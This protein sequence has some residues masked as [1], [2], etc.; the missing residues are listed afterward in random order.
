MFY[1]W[2]F[3][4]RIMNVLSIIPAR[5]GSKGVIRKNLKELGGKPLVTYAI[6]CSLNSKLVTRTIVSTDDNE[7][8][9]ISKKY[10]AEVMMRPSELAQDN[11][12]AE[13]ALKHV[14]EELEKKE[15]Y[16]PD[17]VILTQCTCPFRLSKDIDESITLLKSGGYSSVVSV[18]ETPGHFH[19]YRIKKVINGELESVVKETGMINK[20]LESDR[21]YVRQLLPGKY[22]W[23]NG[24]IYAILYNTLV[25]ENNRYG[26][27]CGALILPNERLVNIDSPADFDFAEYLLKNN[28]IKLD[29]EIK[30]R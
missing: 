24:A 19:P 3:I 28:K 21:Y 1:K 30:E 22:Y 23:L 10:G 16:K 14:L 11:S 20:I 25:K 27:K 18:S 5:G 4:I 9:E 7:I 8:A 12:R 15:N 26:K 29:F 2:F 6:A 17:V 13:E